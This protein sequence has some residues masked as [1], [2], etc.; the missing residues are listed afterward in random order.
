MPETR[1]ARIKQL[2]TEHLHPTT[3]E[4]IDDGHKHQGHAHDGAG[5]FTVR[6][7]SG[8]FDGLSLLQCHRK[9][10]AALESMMNSDI[11]ALSIHI[12]R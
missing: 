10:Y 1:V 7:A 12:E 6:I 3:L 11:H 2:L 4:I 8:E 5:H 9:V